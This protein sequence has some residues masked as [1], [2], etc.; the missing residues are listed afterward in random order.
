M[1]KFRTESPFMAEVKDDFV[2]KV[3]SLQGDIP[4][5][6]TSEVAGFS[7]QRWL[8]KAYPS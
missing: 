2:L 4:D 5:R 6:S 1:L 8:D 3:N 7:H